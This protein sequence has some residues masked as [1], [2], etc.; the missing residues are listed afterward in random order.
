[1]NTF[2]LVEG[3][4]FHTRSDA[5]LRVMA[6]LQGAW[7]LVRA[8]RVVPRFLRDAIYDWVARNRYRWFGR[9][10]KCMV[11]TPELEGRFLD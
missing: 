5:A 4:R 11:P 3:G 1:M 7:P 10:E 2:V 8:L 6:Y 9:E